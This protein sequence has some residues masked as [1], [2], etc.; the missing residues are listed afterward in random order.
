MSQELLALLSGVQ[1]LAHIGAR[2]RI[3]KLAG[4][5]K[6]IFKNIGS[7]KLPIRIFTPQQS[8]DAIQIRAPLLSAIRYVSAPTPLVQA[9]S[10]RV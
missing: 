6:A 3:F 4:L 10:W 1:L 7:L 9:L 5:S 2:E 8:S